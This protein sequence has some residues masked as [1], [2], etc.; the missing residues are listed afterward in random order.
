MQRPSLPCGVRTPSSTPRSPPRR[1]PLRRSASTSSHTSNGRSWTVREARSP[2]RRRR[3]RSASPRLPCPRAQAPCRGSP[4]SCAALPRMCVASGHGTSSWTPHDLDLIGLGAT[5][6]RTSSG[7]RGVTGFFAPA[8]GRR[9]HGRA[10]A[11]QPSRRTIRSH[12]G[13]RPRAAAGCCADGGSLALARPG[14]ECQDIVRGP[15]QPRPADQRARGAV[16]PLA[17]NLRGLADQFLRLVGAQRGDGRSREPGAR[18]RWPARQ[19]VLLMPSSHGPVTFDDLAQEHVWP[20]CDGAGQWTAL[21][22]PHDSGDPMPAARLARYAAQSAIAYVMALPGQ[23][24]RGFTLTPI[25]LVAETLASKGPVQ[26]NL[27]FDA[28]GSHIMSR[29]TFQ[30]WRG[31]RPPQAE[32]A[33]LSLCVAAVVHACRVEWRFGAGARGRARGAGGRC[34]ARFPQG[35]WRAETPRRGGVPSKAL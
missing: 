8:P 21:T 35:F 9:L 11:R 7:A 22:L 20:V 14:C 3:S 28:P 23:D 32:G 12:R 6:W 27:K 26:A 13:L 30:W 19:P 31:R 34:R 16:A 10:R 25:A 24:R 15:H 1:P 5:A 33:S 2:R 18:R 17:C 4:A 29:D